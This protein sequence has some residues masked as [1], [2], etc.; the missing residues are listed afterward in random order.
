MNYLDQLAQ[1]A[2]GF[3]SADLPD[4]VRIRTKWILADCLAVIA[5]GMK[6]PEMQAFTAMHLQ[7]QAPG[8]AWVIGAGLATNALGAAFLNGIAGTWHEL[9]EGN[10]LSKGHPGI[11][12]VPAALAAAQEAHVSGQELLAAIAIGYEVSSR[13]NRAG[14]IRPTIHP[15]GTFGVIGAAL[16]VARVCKL[17]T[18]S[19][20]QLINVAAG[21]PLASSYNSINDGATVRNVFTGHSAFM[22][23]NAVRLV[24]AGFTGEHDAVRMSY[25]TV[26]ADGFDADVAVAGL[27]TDWMTSGGYFKLQPVARSIHPAIDA[28]ED[29]LANVAGGRLD[30]TRIAAIRVRTYRLAANKNQK[31]IHTA[32]G[33]KFSIPFAIA[34]RI[35]NHRATLDCF[36]DDDVA[37]PAIQTLLR[38]I[39]VAED[40]AMTA[41][42]PELQPCS[43]H[44]DMD[45]GTRYAGRCDVVRGEP[46]KPNVVQE[47][48]DKFMDLTVP[49]W[50][51][52][53]AAELFD[54]C[55]AFDDIPDVAQWSRGYV[56]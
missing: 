39:D 22:G 52:S 15:H 8:S 41:A 55:M 38:Q 56:L 54:D 17:P 5:A 40:P 43:V 37:N 49:I 30:A 46:S 2:S 16:A 47:I 6:A 24:A 32:F 48:H 21:L 34:T 28:V 42:Y 25:G 29:A 13:I 3:N 1:F 4:A 45:D 26:L 9:D 18:S 35:V 53:D 11:Q 51:A 31:D 50:G 14:H 10:T 27:G 20:R 44:I 19:Y 33:A 7:S 36:D 12:V 23:I